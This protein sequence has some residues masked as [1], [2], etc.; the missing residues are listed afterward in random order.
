MTGTRLE[1]GC[2]GCSAWT[3]PDS[4]VHY[5]E[6]WMTEADLRRRVRS[7]QFTSVLAVMESAHEPPRLQ[8]DFVTKTRGLDYVA[9]VRGAPCPEPAGRQGSSGE[10][11]RTSDR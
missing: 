3:E 1:P 5:V 10:S 7:A 2:Q 8:F 6:E 11:R 9:E 4:T